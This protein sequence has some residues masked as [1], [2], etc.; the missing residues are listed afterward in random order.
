M[1]LKEAINKRLKELN[2]NQ[3]DLL[4]AIYYMLPLAE[5][6]VVSSKY[7][8][9]EK[10]K[11]NFSKMLNG[12]RNIPLLWVLA[13]EE[14]LGRSLADI[15][16]GSDE[17]LHSFIPR[18]IAYAAY[19][20][21]RE[22]YE[23]L[24]QEIAEGDVAAFYYIQDEFSK[25]LPEYIVEY[26]SVEGV[27]YLL[28]R[29]VTV[30]HSYFLANGS[31]ADGIAHLLADRNEGELLL[32]FADPFA[33]Y[34]QL[35]H[36][37]TEL[38]NA[39][40][41]CPEAVEGLCISQERTFHLSGIFREGDKTTRDGAVLCPLLQKVFEHALQD[42][43]KHKEAL[44]IM[45]QRGAEHNEQ[46][47]AFLAQATGKS[48]IRIEDNGNVY[49]DGY[50]GNMLL[51]KNVIPPG[52]PAELG[53]CL[54]TLA[55]Q[56]QRVLHIEQSDVVCGGFVTADGILWRPASGN[57]AEY[58]MLKKCEEVGFSAVPRYY[59]TTDGKDKLEFIEETRP[60]PFFLTETDK[61]TKAVMQ[62]LREFHE[63]VR[64]P[65]NRVYV[66]G[67]LSAKYI[68]LDA[69]GNCRIIGWD[70]C[71]VGEP[72]D[73]IFSFLSRWIEWN[74]ITF[75]REE[76]LRKFKTA[77]GYYSA[78]AGFLHDI[79]TRLHT[80]LNKRIADEKQSTEQ[81]VSLMMMQIFAEVCKT[82]LNALEDDDELYRTEY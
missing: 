17:K 38:Y 34:R 11:G 35:E 23:D 55:E 10:Q 54:F 13:I 32:K 3:T 82:E 58:D 1:E 22:K 80:W 59:G 47:I 16:K 60:S 52:I 46:Q 44:L 6:G 79:G 74:R 26:A 65:Q 24:M 64:D 30:N 28:D 21:Q 50:E 39:I 78:D 57:Q 48:K 7:E 72:E 69:D 56:Y 70:A 49:K 77:L 53:R 81:K 29:E 76:L 8:F 18:G 45:A 12:E 75:Q 37:E 68:I 20:D 41:D 14:E 15:E 33:S 5:K 66:H 9:A 67:R 31:V 71:S 40:L 36:K 4:Y 42:P 61:Y 27:R 51:F 19:C 43:Q 2:K 73:D 63:K 25:T 62:F